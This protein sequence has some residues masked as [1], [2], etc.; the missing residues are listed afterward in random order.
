MASSISLSTIT[1]IYSNRN[2][3]DNISKIML[4]DGTSL[5]ATGC[6]TGFRVYGNKAANARFVAFS[7]PAQIDW[8]KDYPF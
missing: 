5:V 2:L 4:Q 7:K 8:S 3:W 6:G 1:E